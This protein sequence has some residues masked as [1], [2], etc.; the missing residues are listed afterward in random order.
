[1][2]EPLKRLEGYDKKM[3]QSLIRA[4]SHFFVSKGGKLYKKGLD[5]V[6][7]LVVEKGDQMRMLASAHNSLGHRGAYVM[8][9]LIAECFWWPEYERNVHWYCKT[10][11]L[12]QEQQKTLLKVSPI[13]THTPSLFQRLYVDTMSMSPKFNEY[14]H[15]AHGRCGMTSWM[16]GCP[17]KEETGRSIG[18]WLFEDVVC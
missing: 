14:G 17:L 15:I 7:K 16:E 8:R 9:M 3:I 13:V 18:I 2:I 10:C 4:A 6:H 11:Q 12:C 5:S 1:M